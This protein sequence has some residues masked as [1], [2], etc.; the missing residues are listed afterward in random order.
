MLKEQR[1]IIILL[2]VAFCALVTSQEKSGIS[3]ESNLKEFSGEGF[4]L[5]RA[6]MPAEILKSPVFL[7]LEAKGL[8]T[9]AK[10]FS[11]LV[12]VFLEEEE[13]ADVPLAIEYSAT[14]DSTGLFTRVC[15]YFGN[16]EIIKRFREGYA[17]YGIEEE[18][19]NGYKLISVIKP[20]SAEP[21]PAVC[22]HGDFLDCGDQEALVAHYQDKGKSTSEVSLLC[23]KALKLQEKEAMTMEFLEGD[24]DWARADLFSL[25][26]PPDHS[27]EVFRAGEDLA[28][29]C[30]QSY[31]SN[32]LTIRKQ[33]YLA[34]GAKAESL[35]G[36]VKQNEK[37]IMN[38]M[39]KSFFCSAE[40]A[41][42]CQQAFKCSL[43]VSGERGLLK[44]KVLVQ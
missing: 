39:L 28:G 32:T 21:V 1:I 36:Y 5:I 2:L 42:A 43:K 27:M 18:Y 26:N 31:W 10:F 35:Q 22:L 29:F 38:N 44:I 40:I 9:R 34:K 7:N 14:S 8:I 24:S 6:W 23:K 20:D 37:K 19:I 15:G 33:Y 16:N 3:I 30:T 17:H 41:E 4:N 25:L 12:D 11:R 13:I